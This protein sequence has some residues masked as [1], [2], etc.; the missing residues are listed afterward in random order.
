M[1][2][3]KCNNCHCD[4]HCDGL[5]THHFDGD[6]CTCEQ[7][8]CEKSKAQDKTYESGGLVIDDTGE[9]DSCQ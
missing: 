1:A 8:N 3:N 5:H 4:C 9:C 7:C 6:V 2:L